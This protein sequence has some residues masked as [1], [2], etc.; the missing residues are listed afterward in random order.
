M[1]DLSFMPEEEIRNLELLN[2]ADISLTGV[3]VRRLLRSY[4]LSAN[5]ANTAWFVMEAFRDGLPS[6][7][8]AVRCS[9]L[10]TALSE[11]APK[12]FPRLTP[13]QID[14]LEEIYNEAASRPHQVSPEFLDWFFDVI[15][16]GKRPDT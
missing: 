16:R 10:Q 13:M 14:T 12:H 11:Y 8:V 4:R 9:V 6:N 1:A 3:Q 2:D 15:E 7:E 5:V